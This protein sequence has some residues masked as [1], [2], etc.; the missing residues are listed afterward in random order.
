[1][2]I[3][4][5]LLYIYAIR[6]LRK[7]FQADKMLDWVGL[8]CF[9]GYSFQWGFVSFLLGVTIG[10][11]FLSFISICFFLYDCVSLFFIFII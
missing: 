8:T 6:P 9:F 11:L 7:T 4:I 3:S 5:F 2:V 10:L 1:M